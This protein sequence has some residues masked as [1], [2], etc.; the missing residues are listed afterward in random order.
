MEDRIEEVRSLQNYNND[1][2]LIPSLS[3]R[4]HEEAHPSDQTDLLANVH[5]AIAV[6]TQM[7]PIVESSDDAIGPAIVSKDL[8]GI[9]A[10]CNKRAEKLFR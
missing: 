6:A 8:D 10:S 2:T 3:A 5:D 7:A 1:L 4:R 9:I